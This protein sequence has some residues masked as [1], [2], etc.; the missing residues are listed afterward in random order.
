MRTPHN[1]SQDTPNVLINL[2]THIGRYAETKCLA[3]NPTRPE[4]LAVGANDPFVR[5]YDRRMIIP[6]RYKVKN[7]PMILFF[8]QFSQISEIGCMTNL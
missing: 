2:I 8:L 7:F 6:A 3:V 5:L 1:C 4:L